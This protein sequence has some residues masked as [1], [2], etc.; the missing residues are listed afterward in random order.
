MRTLTTHKPQ[1]K[2]P[3]PAG[4]LAGEGLHDITITEV[5]GMLPVAAMLPGAGSICGLI[6][7][8]GR[9]VPV[10]D[11]RMAPQALLPLPAMDEQI[12]ILAG[13]NSQRRPVLFG[14]LVDSEAAA[15]ELVFSTTH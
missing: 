6:P 1:E 12:C 11:L 15:Y 10:L 5:V 7:F 3:P 9:T 14:A 8:R 2:T 4:P 13:E